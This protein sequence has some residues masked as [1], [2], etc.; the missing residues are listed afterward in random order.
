MLN[1][2][3]INTSQ[4]DLDLATPLAQGYDRVYIKMGG[5][6][7]DPTYEAPHYDRQVDE[8]RALGYKN[9]GHYWVPNAD[10]SDADDIDTPEQQADFM[11]DNLRNWNPKTDFIILDNESLD[12]AI[13]FNDSQAAAFVRRVKTRLNI[14]D[15]AMIGGVSQIIVYSGLSDARGTQWPEVLSTGTN[16]IIAAYSY[17]PFGWDDFASIPANRIVGH[18]TGGK[19]FDGIAT[20]VNVF[21]DDAFDYTAVTNPPRPQPEPIGLSDEDVNRIADAVADRIKQINYVVE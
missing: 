20:D 13:R 19:V 2:I 3:D 9:I 4:R 18:Q 16:F 5:D 14:P 1:V 21:K 12:G 10:P 17:P 11:I 7:V 8:C 6:N 15:G